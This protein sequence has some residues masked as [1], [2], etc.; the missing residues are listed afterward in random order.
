[1]ELSCVLEC[2]LKLFNASEKQHSEE[3]CTSCSWFLYFTPFILLRNMLIVNMFLSPFIR[4]CALSCFPSRIYCD[5]A[6]LFLLP[7]SSS[8]LLTSQKIDKQNSSLPLIL[9]I[10]K[11]LTQYL[12]YRRPSIFEMNFVWFWPEQSWSVVHG[13][14]WLT[15]VRT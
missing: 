13:H 11:Y 5:H 15:G 10:W 12:K 3:P 2:S 8:S 1:M 9:Q 7:H 6:C 14:V 4:A